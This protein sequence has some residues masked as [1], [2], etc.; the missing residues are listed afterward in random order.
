MKRAVWVL[1][2]LGVLAV[3]GSTALAN[4]HGGRHRGG[5]RFGYYGHYYPAYYGRPGVPVYLPNLVAPR[6]VY[7]PWAYRWGYSPYQWG[8]YDPY[9]HGVVRFYGNGFGFVVRY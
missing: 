9:Q 6:P 7:Q 1:A 4:D 5:A 3:A 8:Y 2:F